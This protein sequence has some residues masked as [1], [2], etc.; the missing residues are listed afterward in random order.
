[1]AV[2]TGPVEGLFGDAPQSQTVIRR[3]IVTPAHDFQYAGKRNIAPAPAGT[4]A[5][6]PLRCL[7]YPSG[8]PIEPAEFAVSVTRVGPEGLGYVDVVGSGCLVAMRE[9]VIA[10]GE[11]AGSAVWIGAV[12]RSEYGT[13]D[14]GEQFGRALTVGGVAPCAVARPHE[15]TVTG[16]SLPAW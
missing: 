16:P 7:P 8:A 5:R 14:E 12:A 10:V 6:L 9:S 2:S 1:M 11:L 15:H 3:G 13:D 4:A